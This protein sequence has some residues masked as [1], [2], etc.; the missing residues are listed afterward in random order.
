[1]WRA[2]LDHSH[3]SLTINNGVDKD[4]LCYL[5]HSLFSSASSLQ[6]RALQTPIAVAYAYY[7]IIEPMMAHHHI[8]TV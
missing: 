7:S 1:V 4:Q 5:F 6:P 8:Y 2:P 3:S